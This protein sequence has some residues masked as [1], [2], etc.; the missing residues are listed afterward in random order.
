MCKCPSLSLTKQNWEDYLGISLS[1]ALLRTK[2]EP[3]GLRLRLEVSGED[4]GL[5]KYRM[6]ALEEVWQWLQ[7]ITFTL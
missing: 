2:S 5:M 1:D 4:K 7:F 3:R 6:A